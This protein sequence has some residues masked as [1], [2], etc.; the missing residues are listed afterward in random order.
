MVAKKAHTRRQQQRDAST[1]ASQAAAQA[2][3][4]RDTEQKKEQAQRK[5]AE[6]K[7][8]QQCEREL[9][10]LQADETRLAK[11]MARQQ[12]LEVEARQVS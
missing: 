1:K 2:Q 7:E 8:K 6:K 11:E 9:A 10:A 12:Q 5:A 3:A 4:K